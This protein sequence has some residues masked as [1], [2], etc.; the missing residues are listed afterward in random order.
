MRKS[1]GTSLRSFLKKL[2]KKHGI[3]LEA[4]EGRSINHDRYFQN[5]NKC[6]HVTCLREP[7]ARIKSSY[8]F[9]GRWPQRDNSRLESTAKS[10]SEW[11]SQINAVQPR[12][13]L[14]TCA[15]NYY[16]KSLINYPARGADGIGPE[17]FELA[18]ATLQRFDVVL[19]TEWIQSSATLHYLQHSF[20]STIPLPH[21]R[22]TTRINQ[23]ADNDDEFIDQEALEQVIEDNY[24]DCQLYEFACEWAK[25]QMKCSGADVRVLDK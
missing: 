3:R 14:W 19:I 1:G 11:I 9:E 2:S 7:I 22:K 12:K 21:L 8:L 6:F 24:W 13:R 4:V 16:T 17:E 25:F 5:A 23:S 18:K 10:F 20:N 15:S